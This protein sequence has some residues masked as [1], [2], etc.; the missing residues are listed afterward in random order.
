VRLGRALVVALLAGCSAAP[1]PRAPIPQATGARPAAGPI[2]PRWRLLGDWPDETALYVDTQ[3]YEA[4]G[5]VRE[6]WLKLVAADGSAS[7][8]QWMLDCSDRR[9]RTNAQFQYR[10]DGSPIEST[11]EPSA[12]APAEAG[13]LDEELL[14]LFC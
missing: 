7:V 5:R 4:K 12:W 1:S 10:S 13:T 14:K 2:D 8:A 6:L 3:T 11:A 9:V